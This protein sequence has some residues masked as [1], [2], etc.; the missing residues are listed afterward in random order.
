MKRS[1]TLLCAAALIISVCGCSNTIAVPPQLT[2]KADATSVTEASKETPSTTP[3]TEAVTTPATSSVTAPESTAHTTVTSAVTSTPKPETSVSSHTEQTKTDAP[4]STSKPVATAGKLIKH[5]VN[6]LTLTYDDG[7]YF[8]IGESEFEE[9][10]NELYL[11]HYA[12][13]GEVTSNIVVMCSDE[14][15]DTEGKSVS[16]I[17]ETYMSYYTVGDNIVSST[18]SMIKIGST[19]VFYGTVK[20]SDGEYSVSAIQHIYFARHANKVY[21]VIALHLDYNEEQVTKSLE[22]TLNSMTFDY[23]V[24]T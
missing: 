2:Q 7:I 16:E 3:A 8:D 17:G 1:L 18:K 15:E 14:D 5:S 9:D 13:N 23:S 22:Y 24:N 6:K 20:S 19:D 11:V 4:P 10:N 12:D 21:T